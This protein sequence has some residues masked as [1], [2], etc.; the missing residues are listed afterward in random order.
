MS[1]TK[2]KIS[3][4][5]KETEKVVS[6]YIMGK[7]TVSQ[8]RLKLNEIEGRRLVKIIDNK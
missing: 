8:A 6:E 2:T 5:R 7:I 4:A 3:G 1:S